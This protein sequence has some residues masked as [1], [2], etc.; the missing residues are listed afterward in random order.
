MYQMLEVLGPEHEFALVDETLQPIPMV[1]QVIKTLRGRIAN[2][3]NCRTFTFGKELQA[4]VAEFSAIRPFVSPILF[5]ATMHSA[6][7]YIQEI[8]ST[9]FDAQLLGTG[10]HPLIS[11]NDVKIWPHRDRQIYSAL[12]QIFN[13]YQHGWMNIHAYQLNLPYGTQSEALRLHYL[14]SQ[15]LPYIVAI[16]ASS[17]YAKG[18]SLGMLIPASCSINKARFVFPLCLAASSLKRFLHFT[19]IAKRLYHD[20]LVTLQLTERQNPCC[21]VNG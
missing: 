13:L 16:T 12:H 19:N 4:H 21:N 20:I 18:S 7:E 2:Y 17:P 1:D 11:P 10:M 3:A 5:E 15:I 9:H 8:L 14:I 6:I